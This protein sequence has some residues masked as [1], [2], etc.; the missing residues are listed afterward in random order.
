MGFQEPNQLLSFLVISILVSAHFLFYLCWI[1]LTNLF[2]DFD[3]WFLCTCFSYWRFLWF[4]SPYFFLS[5]I[6][7]TL[8]VPYYPAFFGNI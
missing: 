5:I 6:S 1:F 3:L 4:L 2:L 7:K 8:E